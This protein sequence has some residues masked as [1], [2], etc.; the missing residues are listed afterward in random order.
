ME[1]EEVKKRYFANRNAI[2]NSLP[3]NSDASEDLGIQLAKLAHGMHSH[4]Y[5]A[6]SQE[7]IDNPQLERFR[8]APRMLKHIVGRGHREFSS[9]KQQDSS[10]YFQHLLSIIERA[11]KNLLPRINDDGSTASLF[12]FEMEHRYQCT[13]T[14]T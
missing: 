8:V 12:S 1:V 4:E 2:I 11:E 7:E 3:R 5:V 13:Q 6:L 14:G 10:E 9:N